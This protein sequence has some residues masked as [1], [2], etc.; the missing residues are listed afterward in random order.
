MQHQQQSMPNAN[1]SG[2][3]I[4]TVTVKDLLN[5]QQATA[6]ANAQANQWQQ[7]QLALS[8]QRTFDLLDK[9]TTATSWVWMS[10][11]KTMIRLWINGWKCIMRT[12]NREV[13]GSSGAY[14][15]LS[16]NKLR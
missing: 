12:Y 14:E 3:Q 2:E 5:M 7:A 13:V 10:C 11:A 8:Q 16:K 6:S 15:M 1:V 9:F 4:I